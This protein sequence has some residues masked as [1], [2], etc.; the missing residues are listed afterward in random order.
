MEVLQDKQYKNFEYFSRYQNVP[1]YFHKVDRKYV[2]GTTSH[3]NK[4]TPYILY[5][6]K[7]NDTLDTISLNY[8]NNPTYF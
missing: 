7:I 6:V 4:N 3:I 5:K 8:Y 1:Y 2:S